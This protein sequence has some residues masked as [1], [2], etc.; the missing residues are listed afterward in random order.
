MSAIPLCL[1]K[2]RNAGF[3]FFFSVFLLRPQLGGSRLYTHHSGCGC[4]MLLPCPPQQVDGS[5]FL[6]SVRLEV[7]VGS[8]GWGEALGFPIPIS[9]L[10]GPVPESQGKGFLSH[11]VPP[12]WQTTLPPTKCSSLFPASLLVEVR[13]C[14]L[15]LWNLDLKG[16][17]PLPLQ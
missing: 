13:L 2:V 4:L 6:L 1:C 16:F 9:G 12:Q 3:F 10:A 15:S 8:K 5:C 14:F 7:D 11:T 17:L